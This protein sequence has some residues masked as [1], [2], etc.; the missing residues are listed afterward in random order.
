MPLDAN[1]TEN[2]LIKFNFKLLFCSQIR[3]Q[4]LFP[5]GQSEVNHLLPLEHELLSASDTETDWADVEQELL[6]AS[7]TETDWADVEQEMLSASNTETDWAA[8]ERFR[9]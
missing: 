2:W 3:D 6:S 9:S 1:K 4:S 5:N 7:D 8:A